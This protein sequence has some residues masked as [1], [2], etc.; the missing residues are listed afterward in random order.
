MSCPKQEMSAAKS[1]AEA[2][3]H[4]S[5]CQTM[6][7][8]S[9]T[10][11]ALLLHHDA[12]LEFI[13]LSDISFSLVL[14]CLKHSLWTTHPRR[15]SYPSTRPWLII[16]EPWLYR[17]RAVTEAL[18]AGNKCPSRN[19]QHIMQLDLS[20]TLRLRRKTNSGSHCKEAS[21]GKMFK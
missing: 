13:P 3:I 17:T 7:L 6:V 2:R 5:Q 9:F 15:L 8:K 14:R 18:E 20:L 1:V 4:F 19:N 12:S 11:R 16:Q 21:S 10:T